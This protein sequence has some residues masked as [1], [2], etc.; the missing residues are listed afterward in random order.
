[1]YVTL[2]VRDYDEALQY[3][4]EQLG[5]TCVED[6]VLTETKRWIVVTPPGS[7]CGLLLARATS[8]EQYNRVGDQTGGRVSFFLHTDD[9]W[10]DYERLSDKGVHFVRQPEE[11]AFGWVNVFEDLYGNRWDLVEY[12]KPD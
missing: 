11:M 2:L 9:F 4:C 8:E 6:T 10:R 7:E 5:F 3:Y 12:R 1:M